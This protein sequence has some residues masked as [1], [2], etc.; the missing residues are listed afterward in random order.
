MTINRRFVLTGA[1]ILALAA[2]SGGG[3]ALAQDSES[4]GSEHSAVEPSGDDSGTSAEGT[5]EATGE[6]EATSEN[7]ATN[8]EGTAE[9]APATQ[10]EATFTG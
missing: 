2:G 6:N 3:W 7:E 10:S 4:S 9:A 5:T 8:E 1:A